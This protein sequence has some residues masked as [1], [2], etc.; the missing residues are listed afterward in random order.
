MKSS[1]SFVS[2]PEVLLLHPKFRTINIH[3]I[4]RWMGVCSSN[5][6]PYCHIFPLYHKV[7]HLCKPPK[8]S[9]HTLALHHVS[10]CGVSSSSSS[11]SCWMLVHAYATS[12]RNA[13]WGGPH[14]RM[15][16]ENAFKVHSITCYTNSLVSLIH[17]NT[18]KLCNIT[19]TLV[20]TCM[21]LHS[22]ECI[23]KRR[24]MWKAR[25]VKGR[26]HGHATSPGNAKWGGPHQLGWEGNAFKF[27][28]VRCYTN[29]LVLLI[30]VN[31]TE[32][33][34]TTCTLVAIGVILQSLECYH[35]KQ[36]Q[37]KKKVESLGRERPNLLPIPT[38]LWILCKGDES[39][40]KF[41]VDIKWV[42]QAYHVVW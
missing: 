14:Q 15:W 12:S 36:L 40:A 8:K 6:T 26:V 28:S 42:E 24:R 2:D 19:C 1:V 9:T 3:N 27:H 39:T 22:L 38:Q 23:I 10:I 21:I 18:T 41:H 29:S 30:H 37:K 33:R 5:F 13:K 25:V 31:T 17:V 7:C 20:A 4:T 16:Q 11:A 34:N 35:Q 32:L